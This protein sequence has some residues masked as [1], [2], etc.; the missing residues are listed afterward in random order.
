M[1]NLLVVQILIFVIILFIITI[2]LSYILTNRVKLSLTITTILTQI[3]IIVFYIYQIKVILNSNNDIPQ[4][5]ERYNND[6]N[7]VNDC[8]EKYDNNCNEKYDNN[9]NERYDNDSNEIK[10]NKEPYKH[11]R[12]SLLPHMNH[13]RFTVDEMKKYCGDDQYSDKYIE[14]WNQKNDMDDKLIEIQN[15][16][17]NDRLKSSITKYPMTKSS[18]TKYPMT[19]CPIIETDDDNVSNKLNQADLLISQGISKNERFDV[20]P[21]Y[22]N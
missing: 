12:G 19:K 17:I 6:L 16:Q 7:T 21:D 9:C 15:N 10:N 3:L 18:I 14:W 22:S 8:N 2:T 4:C 5:N 11:F 1:K 13:P 20:L